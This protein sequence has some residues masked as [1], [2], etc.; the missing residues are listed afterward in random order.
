MAKVAVLGMGTMG[1]RLA[2]S[3]VGAGHAVTAW[4]RSG[5]PDD[6]T[7]A[8]AQAA[9][10]PAE[11]ALGADA[12]I[13]VLR[14][15]DASRAVW[16]GPQGVLASMA[17]GALALECSTL[18]ADRSEAFVAEAAGL[19]VAAVVAPLV[20]SRP[21]AEAGALTFLVG[22]SPADRVRA[23]ALLGPVGASA[24]EVGTAG[25]AAVLKLAINA[26]LAVQ[27]ALVAELDAMVAARTSPESGGLEAVR[28]LPVFS[29]AALGMLARM[30][31]GNDDPNFTVDLMGKDLDYVLGLVDAGAAPMV[32]QARDV[33]RQASLH[34]LGDR[35]L[36]VVR[37]LRG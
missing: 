5:V 6:V 13:S 28:D 23:V 24:R 3:L 27:T 30:Q 12:V 11:A 10:T 22:G 33:Y 8:G 15:D 9:P 32:E 35:D 21:Q 14:D 1:S 29:P 26:S 16:S 20:G 34:G 2:R 36:S 31:A 17:P 4:S 37:R 18:T 19:G 7:A 25:D